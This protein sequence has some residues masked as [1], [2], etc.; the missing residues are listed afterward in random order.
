MER[1]VE[2][3]G[4]LS[5]LLFILLGIAAL[6]VWFRH[7]DQASKWVATGFGALAV[8]V[9][10]SLF[11]G[12]DP[13]AWIT[14]VTI[15]GILVWPYTLFRFAGTVDPMPRWGRW[16][17]DLGLAALAVATLV[18]DLPGPDEPSTTAA[19]L[20]VGA[21]ILY[22]SVLAGA[23]AYRLWRAG[24]GQPTLAR[25]RMRFL[26]AAAVLVS[27]ALIVQG[28]VSEQPLGLQLFVQLLTISSSVSFLVAFVPPRLLRAAWRAPEEEE[29]YRA[30]VK[31]MGARTEDEVGDV[32]LPHLARVVGARAVRLVGEEGRVLGVHGEPPTTEPV[33]V[34]LRS[35]GLE[36]WMSRYTPFF[37][38]EEQRLLTRLGLLADLAM[39]RAQ[40]LHREQQARQEVEAA[41][42]E[43]EAFVYSASHD[44]KTPVLAL[45]G[46][47][48]VIA[49][50]DQAFGPDTSFYL[51]RM[52]SNALYMEELISDLLELSRI[53]RV[54]TTPQ[55][56]PLAEI[57][58][59]VAESLQGRFPEAQV[60]IDDGLPTLWMNRTRVRQLLSNLVENSARYGGRADVTIRVW[61]DGDD[62]HVA[63]D[64]QGIPV[65]HQDRVFRMFE[66]LATGEGGTG[67]G[68]AI[69]RKIVNEVGGSIG[70]VES[71]QGAHV[72]I[73]LPGTALSTSP[74]EAAQKETTV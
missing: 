50:E 62:I 37:G 34:P 49:A 61:A 24:R 52:R 27:L 23:V 35:G 25:R 12:E 10:I 32:L 14:T 67:I 16:G 17:A 38:S 33:R 20:F 6:R 54:D 53:G 2:V 42:E 66:R 51:Q 28:A 21:F 63:D 46:F 70:F 39:A 22:W 72:R 40:L 73:H 74:R 43:L 36:V 4:D 9:G 31:L 26:A 59:E 5:S 56:V 13:P 47:L 71:Q 8:A 65:E 1:T 60:V 58:D 64:G 30:S 57:V 45:L 15:L 69:C 29:L 7:R 18:I 19:D 48:D 3:V 44:L 11:V 68:L 55:E 41:N